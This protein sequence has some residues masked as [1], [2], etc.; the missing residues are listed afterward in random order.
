MEE[1][2]YQADWQ[3]EEEMDAYGEWTP[4]IALKRNHGAKSLKVI[5][6]QSFSKETKPQKMSEILQKLLVNTST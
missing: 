3:G 5:G 1:K 4:V 6:K 2:D